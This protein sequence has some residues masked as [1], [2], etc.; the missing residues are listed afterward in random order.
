MV[1]RC[2]VLVPVPPVLG[3]GFV[4]DLAQLVFDGRVLR[5]AAGR[6]VTRC[7]KYVQVQ[8]GRKGGFPLV[9]VAGPVGNLVPLLVPL[10]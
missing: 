4:L 3:L 1:P 9:I 2:L 7:E 10:V 8:D 5:F 6:E